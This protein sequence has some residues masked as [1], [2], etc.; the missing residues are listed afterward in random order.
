MPRYNWDGQ[1]IDTDDD[2]EGQICPY[3]G[4]YCYGQ[5]CDDYGCAKEA[6]VEDE[7]ISRKDLLT[8][9]HSDGALLDAFIAVGK[10]PEA[11]VWIESG[12]QG[13]T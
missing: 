4:T 2:G 3:T 13:A 10:D 7:T 11:I 9:V 12:D 1:P 8:I 6:G 5:F